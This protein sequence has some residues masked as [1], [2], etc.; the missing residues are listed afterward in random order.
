MCTK[1]VTNN[2]STNVTNVETANNVTNGKNS[3]KFQ[4]RVRSRKSG[5]PLNKRTSRRYTVSGA[6]IE[7]NPLTLVEAGRGALSAP[8]YI[9]ACRTKKC[10]N[11]VVFFGLTFSLLV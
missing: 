7:G 9:F 1:N 2:N 4:D 5:V 10:I 11:N 3:S 6:V 8:R